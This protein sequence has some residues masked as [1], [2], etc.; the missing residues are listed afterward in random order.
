M[1][2]AAVGKQWHEGQRTRPPVLL[3]LFDGTGMARVA[4]DRLLRAMRRPEA[5]VGC[6]FAEI[7]TGLA[8]A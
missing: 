2:T 7:C 5:L 6:C 4:F 1:L 3:S 8:A